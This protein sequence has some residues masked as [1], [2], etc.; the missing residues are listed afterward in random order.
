MSFDINVLI[1]VMD[2]SCIPNRQA[3]FFPRL[4][5]KSKSLFYNKLVR[6]F[7]LTWKTFNIQS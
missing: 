1:I 5:K 6:Q 3:R 7:L 2:D 4:E